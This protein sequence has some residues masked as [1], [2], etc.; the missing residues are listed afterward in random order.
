MPTLLPDAMFFFS[1]GI[2]S[3]AMARTIAMRI[4]PPMNTSTP[5]LHVFV[6]WGTADTKRFSVDELVISISPMYGTAHATKGI[7]Q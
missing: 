7:C 3:R 5:Y 6:A 1:T 4:N 2:V